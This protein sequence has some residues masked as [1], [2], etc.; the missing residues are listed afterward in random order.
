MRNPVKATDSL[1]LHAL[2][3]VRIETCRRSPFLKFLGY[4]GWLLNTIFEP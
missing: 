4:C 2:H 1:T 3:I